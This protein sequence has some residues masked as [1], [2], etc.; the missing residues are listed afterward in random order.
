MTL[1]ESICR[2]LCEVD[3]VDPDGL[4]LQVQGEI[5]APNWKSYE[6]TVAEV[7]TAH[8]EIVGVAH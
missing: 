3:G 1:I 4:W 6:R 8:A 7:L 5:I 2:K